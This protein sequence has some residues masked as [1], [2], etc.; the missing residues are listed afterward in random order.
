MITPNGLLIVT[1]IE[2][3]A[4]VEP[5]LHVPVP[6]RIMVEVPVKLPFTV[7]SVKFPPTVRL[8]KPLTAHEPA[9]VVPFATKLPVNVVF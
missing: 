4:L 2:N 9:P 5:P 1:S 7:P 8:N 6:F 3:K